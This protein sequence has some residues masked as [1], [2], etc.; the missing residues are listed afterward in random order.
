MIS[1]LLLAAILRRGLIPS[2][3][4]SSISPEVW[5]AGES[6]YSARS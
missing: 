3:N 2:S 1:E 5:L 4:A 6:A